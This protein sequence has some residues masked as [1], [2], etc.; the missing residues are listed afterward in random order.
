MKNKMNLIDCDD[1]S[2]SS[3]SKYVNK[4]CMILEQAYCDIDRGRTTKKKG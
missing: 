1:G 4:T 2:L 3:L